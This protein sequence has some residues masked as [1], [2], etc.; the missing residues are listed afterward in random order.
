MLLLE[1]LP[2]RGN[3]HRDDNGLLREGGEVGRELKVPAVV[4][5]HH[6]IAVC[7][8]ACFSGVFLYILRLVRSRE[9]LSDFCEEKERKRE[10]ERKETTAAPSAPP[11][12]LYACRCETE[13]A[14]AKQRKK[15]EGQK[16]EGKTRK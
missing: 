4:G 12:A 13:N 14:G 8:C 11:E 10:R 7:V 6:G 1:Q 5:E 16:K 3:T 2:E 9:R 15:R